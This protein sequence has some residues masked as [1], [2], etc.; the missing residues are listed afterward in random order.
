[1]TSVVRGNWHRA[2]L[3]AI[4]QVIIISSIVTATTFRWRS[5]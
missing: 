3:F 4:A 2:L 1:M 5:V